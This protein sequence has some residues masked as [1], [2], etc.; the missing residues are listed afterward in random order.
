[1]KNNASKKLTLLALTLFIVFTAIN[2]FWIITM[3][4]PHCGYEYSLKKYKDENFAFTEK[5]D[6]NEYFLIIANPTYL[7]YDDFLKVAIETKGDEKGI[8]VDSLFIYPNIWDDY[9]YYIGCTEN[10]SQFFMIEIDEYCTLIPY[11]DGDTEFNQ[12][13]QKILNEKKSEIIQFINTAKNCWGLE[14][15]HD[16]ETGIKGWINGRWFS[17]AIELIFIATVL[18]L[19]VSSLIW[20][21]KYRIPF[22][23]KFSNELNTAYGMRD[24]NA[25]RTDGDYEFYVSYPQ[26]LRDDGFLM[27]QKHQFSIDKIS[28]VI[29]PRKKK[30]QYFILI[31]SFNNSIRKT[32]KIEI[33]YLNKIVVSDN[34]LVFEHHEEIEDLIIQANLFWQI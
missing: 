7:G 19:V 5:E 9:K 28:L 30:T 3:Y 2:V 34:K 22:K 21:L 16:F 11:N 23:N 10:G 4:I 27:I 24:F 14:P 8:V 15:R 33:E 17:A 29:C 31:N 25:K 20:L 26:V 18:C 1:M 32:D 13:A 6:S 12:K